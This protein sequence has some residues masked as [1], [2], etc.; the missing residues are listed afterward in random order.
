MSIPSP[1][2]L[3]PDDDSSGVTL[4]K[5]RRPLAEVPRVHPPYGLEAAL[6]ALLLLICLR[7]SSLSGLTD[8]LLAAVCGVI[9]Y[10]V[11]L[12][13]KPP[14]PVHLLSVIAG[15]SGMLYGLPDVLIYHQRWGIG[16]FPLL[17][18]LLLAGLVGWLLSHS[19]DEPEHPGYALTAS[20]LGMFVLA[21]LMTLLLPHA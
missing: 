7:A 9:V 15:V 19:W 18:G 12:A 8:L 16:S 10:L 5:D 14:V 20:F 13:S 17:F 6:L 3:T 11:L 21:N 4:A 1:T 2:P